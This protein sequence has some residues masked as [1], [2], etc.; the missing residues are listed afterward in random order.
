[1][2]AWPH[3]CMHAMLTRSRSRSIDSTPAEDGQSF[4]SSQSGSFPPEED[5]GIQK[6]NRVKRR[7]GRGSSPDQWVCIISD[8]SKT[9]EGSRSSIM[10]LKD[11]RTSELQNRLLSNNVVF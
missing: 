1:M 5:H 10:S 3:C 6:K 4:P 11:P 2:R 9:F 7:K 8:S